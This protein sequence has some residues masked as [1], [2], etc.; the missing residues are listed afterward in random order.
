MIVTQRR[1][2]LWQEC[3]SMMKISAACSGCGRQYEVDNRF[4]GKTLKCAHC[5]RPMIIPTMKHPATEPASH[6]S[7][8]ELGDSHATP[9]TTFRNASAS[10][11]YK[12][13]HGR[14]RGRTKK[15][16]SPQK[17]PTASGRHRKLDY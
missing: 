17:K 3:G 5:D 16:T 13:I 14:K 15:K 7:E 10:S 2:R 12:P 9:P 6:L 1:S 4:A 11:E 8:Y